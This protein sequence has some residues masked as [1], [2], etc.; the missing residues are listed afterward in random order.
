M[1]LRIL[2]IHFNKRKPEEKKETPHFVHA[3][4]LR[5]SSIEIIRN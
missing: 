3:S 5:F 4:F 1:G 2:K